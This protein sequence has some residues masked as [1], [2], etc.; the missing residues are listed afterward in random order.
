MALS[1]PKCDN[2]LLKVKIVTRPEYG[3]DILNDAEQTTEIEVEQCMACHGVWFDVNELDQYLAEKL[4]ILNSP[5][6]PNQKALDKK[7]GV[8][9]KCKSRLTKKDAPKKAGFKMDICDQCKGVW[10]DSAEID[11]LEKKNFS[12]GEKHALAFSDL[13]RALFGK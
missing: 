12:F 6:L 11:K 7:E 13:K 8:C 10:L 4:L 5:K 3:A 2:T 1:C 9:P